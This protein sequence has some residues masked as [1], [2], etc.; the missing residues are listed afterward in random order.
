[1][2]KDNG[3][4]REAANGGARP[5]LADHGI[6]LRTHRPGEH[7]TACP[8]CAAGKHRPGDTALAVRVDADGSAVWCCFRCNWTGA[9]GAEQDP[10][11][12][13][14]S[15]PRPRPPEPPPDPEAERRRQRAQEL[16][17][18]TETVPDGLPFDYLTRRRGITV[19]DGDRLR[20]HPACPWQGGTAGCIVACVND[21]ATSYTTAIWRIRPTMDGPIE[22]R[23]LG[24]VKHNAARLFW[25][26]GN[27]LLIAEGVEDAL[28]A[29]ALTGLPAWAALSAG[30][31]AELI[32]PER[33]REVTI[34]ADA[35]TV[36][37]GR[38]AA[39]ARRLQREGRVVRLRRPRWA[40]DAND[41]L[42]TRRAG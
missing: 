38:A 1:M 32:L 37:I 31:M 2:A 16:W 35:D 8:E 39:L 19:W 27:E 24:P 18:Q 28:A 14:P 15:R 13:S 4:A 20:W 17:R 25:A 26:S 41:I 7:R 21:H 29:H 12:R 23:G 40:K 11:R 30:N 6:H 10:G 22:R 36:G 3:A 34:F 9:T 5:S 42:L 33:F